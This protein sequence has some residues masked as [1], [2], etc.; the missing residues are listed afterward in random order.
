MFIDLHCDTI[1]RLMHAPEPRCLRSNDFCV[2]VNKLTAGSALAQFFA[3]YLDAKAPEN[4]TGL[5]HMARRHIARFKAEVAA[6][7]DKM[8]LATNVRELDKCRTTG[9]IAAFLTIEEGGIIEGRLDNLRQLYDD[10]VRLATLTWNYP[11]EIGYPNCE[12]TYRH[13]GLTEFGREV[14]TAMN[15]LNMIIDV[16]HL[17]DGGFKDVAELSAKPFVASHSNSR[18]LCDHPRNLT[19]D[20]IKTIANKGGVVGINFYCNFLG[21]YP[22]GRLTD[23]VAHIRHIYKVGGIE[24]VALG[25]DYDG[26]HGD[27][28]LSDCSRLPLLADALEQH[29]F[30]ADQIDK[31]CWRN[32]RRII[33]DCLG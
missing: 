19:D 30:T 2:D 13:N 8:T 18:F 9:K 4:S 7:S 15:E 25:T 12:S 6:N 1:H 20:M 31:F 3:V 16:S 23:I 10:G 28:E 22:V 33:A 21:N 29:G 32:C 26:Y 5:F 24:T 17:S 27:N 11:N 14:V